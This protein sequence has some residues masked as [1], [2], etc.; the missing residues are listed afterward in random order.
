MK[1]R[2][3][4]KHL[5]FRLRQHDVA[6][7]SKSGSITDRI[8]FGETADQQI[9]YSLQSSSDEEMKFSFRENMIRI[10]IPKQVL[11]K[12]MSTDQVGIEGEL[13]TGM[14]K[15]VSV[16]I[17]KDF[18]CLDATDEDNTGTYP[19]PLARYAD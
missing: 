6:T 11:D 7:L 5:R 19:N 4:G 16:L 10:A 13:S 12:W 9:G 2:I 1:L 8:E 14:N 15:T 18:A 17:E 3:N